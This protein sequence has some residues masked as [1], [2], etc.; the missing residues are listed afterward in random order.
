MV[1][2]DLTLEQDSKLKVQAES[3]GRSVS[4]VLSW[5]LSRVRWTEVMRRTAHTRNSREERGE[6]LRTGD[7]DR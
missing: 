1:T 7:A 4:G 2:T 6:E 5:C 3:I